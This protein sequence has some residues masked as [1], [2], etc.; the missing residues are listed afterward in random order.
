MDRWPA[1]RPARKDAATVAPS[2]RHKPRPAARWAQ[3][4]A[5]QRAHLA[6]AISRAPQA[7]DRG[8]RQDQRDPARGH[9]RPSF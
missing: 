6:T 2:H 9:D 7:T 4:G 5:L 8:A 1:P 3:P